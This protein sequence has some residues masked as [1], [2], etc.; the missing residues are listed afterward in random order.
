M[1]ADVK[2]MLKTRQNRRKK[3][4]PALEFQYTLEDL[5]TGT[6]AIREENLK[7]KLINQVLGQYMQHL[8][9]PLVFSN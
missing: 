4:M 8:M 5:S 3:N 9:P 6:N 1:N 7:L 2:L